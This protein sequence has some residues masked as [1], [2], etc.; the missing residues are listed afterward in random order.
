MLEESVENSVILL[1]EC[2]WTYI[3]HKH[4][5]RVVMTSNA[6]AYSSFIFVIHSQLVHMP[7]VAICLEIKYFN[8]FFRSSLPELFLGKLLWKYAENLQE[9][10]VFRFH[11]F[12]FVFQPFWQNH[13]NLYYI[14]KMKSHRNLFE[15]K[16]IYDG[17]IFQK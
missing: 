1:Y 6:C 15:E 3:F 2:R 11:N 17:A 13:L 4:F 12:S 10:S 16:I 7:F 9:I 5:I 14:L 8:Y